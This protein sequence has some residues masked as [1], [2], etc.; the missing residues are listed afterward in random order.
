[1]KSSPKS[2]LSKS[3]IGTKTTRSLPSTVLTFKLVKDRKKSTDNKQLVDFI[4]YA[5][6][7]GPENAEPTI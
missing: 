1:M 2:S 5:D 6:Q 3:D 4:I 7:D